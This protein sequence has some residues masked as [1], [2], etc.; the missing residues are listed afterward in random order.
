[1]ARRLSILVVPLLLLALAVPA[2][3]TLPPDPNDTPGRLDLLLALAER[4]PVGEPVT[5]MVGTYDD[6]KKSV[7]ARPGR[8]RMIVLFS[9]DGDNEPEYKGRVYAVGKRLTIMISGS[10]ESFENLPV[11]RPDASTIKTIIPASSPVSGDFGLAVRTVYRTDRGSCSTAC[12]DRY[13]DSGYISYPAPT[14]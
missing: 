6:W 1:M 9:T 4:G 12:R 3:A 10:G 11:R 8:N 2:Q 14:P 7:L 5:I 13:P